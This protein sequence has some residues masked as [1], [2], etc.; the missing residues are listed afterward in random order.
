MLHKGVQRPFMLL[1]Q[2]DKSQGF[3]DRVPKEEG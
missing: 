2:R 1:A 3:G